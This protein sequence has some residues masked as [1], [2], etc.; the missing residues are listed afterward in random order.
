MI[1]YILKSSLIWVICSDY[2]YYCFAF[3]YKITKSKI[4]VA[5]TASLTHH[6][7][8]VLTVGIKNVHAN[9]KVSDNK[10]YWCTFLLRN[11]KLL[12]MEDT[13]AQNYLIRKLRFSWWW[14]FSMKLSALLH[15]RRWNS[16]KKI[17]TQRTGSM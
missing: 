9:E 5:F 4:T 13:S 15:H 12:Y 1:G 2:H 16:I 11:N 6:G 3:S 17:P 10:V 8:C 14:W 7:W